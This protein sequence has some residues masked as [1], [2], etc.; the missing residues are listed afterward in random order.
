MIKDISIAII[1]FVGA[2]FLLLT[3]PIRRLMLDYKF[4]PSKF[5]LFLRVLMPLLSILLALY[6]WFLGDQSTLSPPV[7]FTRFMT[8]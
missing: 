3:I 4:K 7:D 2:Y 6:V 5:I 8:S 1:L